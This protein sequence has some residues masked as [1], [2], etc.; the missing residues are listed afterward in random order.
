MGVSHLSIPV[1]TTGQCEY[2]VRRA[3]IYWAYIL[4][5]DLV[6]DPEAGEFYELEASLD[7]ALNFRPAYVRVKS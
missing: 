4:Y 7:Y 3:H 5:R 2:G 1:F 6:A